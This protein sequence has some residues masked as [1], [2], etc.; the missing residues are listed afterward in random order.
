MVAGS[1]IY[2][3]RDSPSLADL[4]SEELNSIVGVY[5]PSQQGLCSGVVVA[6]GLALTARHCLF[7]ER[8]SFAD[9]EIV[10]GSDAYASTLSVPPTSVSLH[11]TL[12]AAVLRFDAAA[13]KQIAP[14]W[15]MTAIGLY[16]GAVDE[17]LVGQNVEIAGFGRADSTEGRLMF[18]HQEVTAID[19]TALTV[20]GPSG[21]GACVGDSGGPLLI[22]TP[23]GA[24]VLG[25]LD[26][27]PSDCM[28]GD[29]YIRSDLLLE[30]VGQS[31]SPCGG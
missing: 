7:A 17:T 8:T 25:I 2:G 14:E 31:V 10:F 5:D 13:L 1:C 23:E 27:G 11:P 16:T 28:G 9:V 22:G 6:A 24:A 3:G 18:A 20:D 19:E 30:L 12:D 4:T 21:T 29:R 15:S 26:Q